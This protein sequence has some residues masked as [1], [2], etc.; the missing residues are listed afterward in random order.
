MFRLFAANKV[1]LDNFVSIPSTVFM[2]ALPMYLQQHLPHPQTH[3]SPWLRVCLAGAHLPPHLHRPNA[4]A[5]APAEG[6]KVKALFAGNADKVFNGLDTVFF[7]GW[8][9]YAQLLIDLFKYL[10]PFLRNVELN[11]PMQILYKVFS[12]LFFVMA[13]LLQQVQVFN[14]TYSK[15]TSFM[16]T[17]V[18]FRVIESVFHCCII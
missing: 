9:M 10:A 5:H 2:T 15:L 4:G 6:S 14:L 1:R 18:L 8:P 13:K 3:Q 17:I 12:C 7:Q 11:K 16:K